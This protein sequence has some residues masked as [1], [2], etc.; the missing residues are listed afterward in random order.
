[1]TLAMRLRQAEKRSFSLNAFIE[2]RQM[3]D[4]LVPNAADS[5][6]WFRDRAGADHRLY[7]YDFY[8][9]RT[10]GDYE[11][12]RL[13]RAEESFEQGTELARARGTRLVVFYVPI[14]FRV[15]GDLCAFPPGSP[16][17]NWH[18]WDLEA[19]LAE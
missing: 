6:G 10:I 1:M 11:L 7:F 17:A 15:Y 4:A 16:C 14:K 9:T 12:E 2:L 8:A 13:K 18:S 19:R 5:F 3:S